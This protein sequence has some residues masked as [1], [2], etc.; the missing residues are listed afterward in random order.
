MDDDFQATVGAV[1]GVPDRV[2][3]SINDNLRIGGILPMKERINIIVGVELMILLIICYALFMAYQ[4]SIFRR[5]MRLLIP[6]NDCMLNYKINSC[7]KNKNTI[8][9]VLLI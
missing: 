8:G 6:S 3:I 7:S 9:I 5:Q 4:R 1:V 2:S